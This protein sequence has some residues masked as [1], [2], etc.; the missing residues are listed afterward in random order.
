MSKRKKRR[1]FDTFDSTDRPKQERYVDQS[2]GVFGFFRDFG[3]RETIESVIVAIVLALM[4][5]AFE[6]EAFIIPTGSMAP[7]LQGQHMDVVCSQCGHQ[8]RAGATY[9]SS[10]V[11]PERRMRVE[12]TYCPIC[13]F[14]MPMDPRHNP[15]HNSNHGDRILVNKFIYDF[16]SPQRFDVIVFKNPN[17]GKQ[18]YI[19]RLVGLPGDN[20]TIEGG[21]VYN[22]VDPKNREIIR[23]PSEKLKVM[24]QLVDDTNY[25]A[26]K[27]QAVGWPK[28]WQCWKDPNGPWSVIDSDGKPQY[29]LEPTED[30]YWLRYRHLPPRVN[31]EFSRNESGHIVETVNS[32]WDAIERGEVPSRVLNCKGELIRDYYEYNDAAN[33]RSPRPD[34]DVSPAAHWVGDFAFECDIEIES[35]GGQLALDLVEG[36]THFRCTIDVSTGMA[37]LASENDPTIVFDGIPSGSQPAAQTALRGPGKYNILYA[38]ADDQLHLW[39]NKRLVKFDS[40]KYTRGSEVLPSYTPE[41]P[42]DAEPAGIAGSNLTARVTR[43]KILRDVYYTSAT[44]KLNSTDIDL[45]MDKIGFDMGEYPPEDWSKPKFLNELRGM[46]EL[47]H[48]IYK[49]GENQF[50]TMGDNSPASLDARVW[51]GPKYVDGGLL[52]G[53]AMFI[54]W[55]HSLNRP[56]KYFPNFKRMGFIK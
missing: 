48:P 1:P 40:S 42:G 2:G 18:N 43:L 7:T 35:S 25:I 56:I 36:G 8:Y 12:T 50:F 33:F 21:D 53:R 27:M 31:R 17:N 51:D 46:R 15:D 11:P 4:F 41:D 3:V 16:S 52:I 24:L 23:K 22:V 9:D 20:L 5:R 44:G 47:D 13:H 28:R 32:E 14:G 19:K 49:L 29:R 34:R 39:I 10:N 37:T 45:A 6:A 30:M 38:N 26:K 55:P 54:Y